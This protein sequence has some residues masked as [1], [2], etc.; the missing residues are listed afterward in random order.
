LCDPCIEKN[1][2]LGG[3]CPKG[4]FMVGD[5]S[6]DVETMTSRPRFYCADCL[7]GLYCPGIFNTPMLCPG[8]AINAYSGGGLY[9]NFYLYDSGT[10]TRAKTVSECPPYPY[11]PI[12]QQLAPNAQGRWVIIGQRR[13]QCIGERRLQYIGERRL[14]YTHK[15]Q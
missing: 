6:V 11:K 13:L 14:Q 7:S 12:A 9:W 3:D 15:Q 2:A 1:Y 10:P 4:Q 5:G 8:G